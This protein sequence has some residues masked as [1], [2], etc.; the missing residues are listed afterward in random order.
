VRDPRLLRQD[1]HT[2]R[3][4]TAE[5]NL[6]D[7]MVQLVYPEHSMLQ[8]QDSITN[9]VAVDLYCDLSVTTT[10]PTANTLVF[11]SDRDRTLALLYMTRYPQFT[12]TTPCKTPRF[13]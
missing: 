9:C 11:E 2:P 3:Y 8:Y 7:P 1:P 13:E 5:V 10:Q 6:E 12:V 4:A